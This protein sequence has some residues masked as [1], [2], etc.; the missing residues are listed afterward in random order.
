MRNFRLHPIDSICIKTSLLVTL[1]LT[2]CAGPDNT[3]RGAA[4]VVPS[5]PY[6]PAAGAEPGVERP[7]IQ[8][9]AAGM[10]PA[11]SGAEKGAPRDVQGNIEQLLIQIQQENAAPDRKK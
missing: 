1:A 8:T 4:A 6:A 2:G 10:A 9:T 3:P 7:T 11:G 5:A